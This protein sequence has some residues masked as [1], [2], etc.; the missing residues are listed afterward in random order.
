MDTDK[1]AE[2]GKAESGNT[3]KQMLLGKSHGQS[4]MDTDKIRMT[5]DEW[6]GKIKAPRHGEP[7]SALH[8]NPCL[9]VFI[10]G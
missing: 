3:N 5:N 9:S 1:K 6:L 2:S 7:G 10:C 4:R 8:F